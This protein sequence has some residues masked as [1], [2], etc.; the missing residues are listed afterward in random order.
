[1]QQNAT[2]IELVIYY[3]APAISANLESTILDINGKKMTSVTE[4][5][6][7]LRTIMLQETN[8]ILTVL[9]QIMCHIIGV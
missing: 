4:L 8:I 1:M 5:A 2:P 6:N 3:D 9:G 7:E